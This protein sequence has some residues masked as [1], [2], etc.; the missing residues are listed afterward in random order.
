V[1][2][3]IQ[4]GKFPGEHPVVDFDFEVGDGLTAMVAMRSAIDS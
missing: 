4:R 2:C 1:Q 3:G